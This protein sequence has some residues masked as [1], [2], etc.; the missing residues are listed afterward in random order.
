[1]TL[2]Q[3]GFDAFIVGGSVRDLLLGLHPKDFDIATNATPEQVKR[4][5]G[6]QC[7]IIGRSFQLAHV[8]QERQLLEVATFRAPHEVHSHQKPNL[9]SRDD[10]A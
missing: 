8:Y 10:C 3:A 9:G 1:M 6:R 5:F 7:Q 4:V 2:H